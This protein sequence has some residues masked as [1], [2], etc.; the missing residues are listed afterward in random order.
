M[1][2]S[3]LPANG[4]QAD[5]PVVIGPA[6]MVDGKQFTPADVLN[7]DEVG[8]LAA[9]TGE[10]ITGAHHTLPVPSYVEVTS[11]ETGRT[12]LVRLE[13]RGPMDSRH[14]LSLSAPAMEQL[15]AS[16]D[17]PIRVRRVNPPETHRAV[18]RAGE[19]APLRMDTPMGLVTVL[20]RRLPEEGSASLRADHAPAAPAPVATVDLAEA[21]ASPPLVAAAEQ[22]LPQVPQPIETID[23][24]QPTLPPLA[25]ADHDAFEQAF[26]EVEDAG[27]D[28]SEVV[29]AELSAETAEVAPAQPATAT[30][31]AAEAQPVQGG[32]VVQAAAF[33]TSERAERVANAL[34][35]QVSR[36]GQFYRVRTGPFTTRAQAE[37]SLANVR[38]AGYSDARIYSNG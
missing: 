20:R 1:L 26:A 12:I 30:P 23:P 13:Q 17:T 8:Y 36:S 2:V 34:G 7:Y 35:G 31:R 38:E 10:G 25:E 37:A 27:E 22:P 14:L 6:Y 5:Y 16:A 32:F 24:E 28:A 11:L 4:P 18:L 15:Q 19:A 21:G 3:A 9:G 29:P 33:S